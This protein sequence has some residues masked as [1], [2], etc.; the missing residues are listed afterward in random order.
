MHDLTFSKPFVSF[1]TYIT[2]HIAVYIN[3]CQS[4]SLLEEMTS[5]YLSLHTFFIRVLLKVTDPMPCTGTQW[6]FA[7]LNQIELNMS[8]SSGFIISLFHAV[9]VRLQS[10]RFFKLVLKMVWWQGRCYVCHDN[11]IF[12]KMHI[13]ILV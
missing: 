5:P 10:H 4:S 3:V 7:E 2:F 12:M 11:D 9:K 13:F 1:T 8:Q 6:I